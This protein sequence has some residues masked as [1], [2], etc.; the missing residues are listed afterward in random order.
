MKVLIAGESWITLHIHMKGF[1]NFTNSTYEEGVGPLREALIRGGIEVDY[2][3]NHVAGTQF[4]LTMEDLKPYSVV[5]LSDI[6]ANT[7]LLNPKSFGEFQRTPNRLELL[8][9][10]VAEG[11]GLCMIGGYLTFQGIEAKGCWKGTA[12]EQVLP[13]ELMATDDRVETPEGVV[14]VTSA[15]KHPILEGIDGPWP[16]FL[17]YNRL[18]AKNEAKV[19]AT[20]GADP[21]LV[22]WEYGKGRAVSFA[23]DCAPHWGSPEFM[24]WKHYGRMWTQLCAWLGRQS[25]GVA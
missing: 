1:D 14:P 18:R 15:L 10:Y 7:L 11:G 12:V 23:S 8:K 2:L 19:L 13:T 16:Y 25:K 5:L 3:P 17:G 4:P 21:F 22:A 24:A 9:N 20:V 6:G